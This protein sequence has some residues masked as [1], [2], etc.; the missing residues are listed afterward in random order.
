MG[1]KIMSYEDSLQLS[2][3]QV[4][5]V[6]HLAT[7]RQGIVWHKIGLGKTRVALAWILA[8]GLSRPL[9]VCS[10]LAFRQWMDEIELIGLILEVVPKFFSYGLLSTEKGF[11]RVN[12]LLER[13]N[14]DCVILDELWLYKNPRSKRSIM[15]GKFAAVYPVLGL[16]GSMIT[17]RNIED[18]F[19]QASAVGIGGMIANSL[20]NFREQFC[21][22]L[23]N[24][25][26]FIER[27]PKK[28][29]VEII[30]GRL[31]DNIHVCFPKETKEIRNIPVNVDPS[32]EQLKYR[33]E[34]IKEYY[35][36]V[37]DIEDEQL[38]FELEVKNGAALLVKLQE[39]SDG[40]LRDNEGNYLSIKSNKLQKLLELISEFL[41]AGERVLVWVA[42]KQTIKQLL[43]ASKFPAVVLSG[44]DQFDS[45]KWSRGE[46]K[47][48]YATIGSGA[49]LNDFANTRYAVIYSSSFSSRGFEQAKGRT[50]RKSSAHSICYYYEFQTLDFPDSKVLKMLKEAA[51]MQDYVIQTTREIV[52]EWLKEKE[53]LKS[54]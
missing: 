39:V 26:G 49:S 47:V 25:A 4:E 12:D 43:A 13:Y 14:C 17:A 51:E 3:E 40:F 23:T 16:S 45:G 35:L 7:K 10:P 33:K 32:A 44:D 2:T 42:F 29:A 36:K 9:V 22:E 24:Y 8:K 31:K 6:N 18:L 1:M 30:Q 28:G 11:R 5:A 48:C 21:I 19:G 52:E 50:N 54:L 38:R 27:V 46:A 15:A 34:L 41:D 53:F 37:K 20:T